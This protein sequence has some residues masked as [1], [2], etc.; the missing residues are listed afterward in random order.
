MEYQ[1][2]YYQAEVSDKRYGKP[3]DSLANLTEDDMAK[4]RKE[5]ADDRRESTWGCWLL[6]H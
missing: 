6:S 2:R 1:A 4:A 5:D 3:H